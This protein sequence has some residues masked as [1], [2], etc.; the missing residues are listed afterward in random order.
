MPYD[1]AVFGD[2]G[3]RDRAGGVPSNRYGSFGVAKT[4]FGVLTTSARY[5]F[6]STLKGDSIGDVGF[7][8]ASDYTRLE[9]R[10]QTIEYG[11]GYTTQSGRYFGAFYA[12][13]IAGKNYNRN[14]LWGLTISQPLQF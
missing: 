8:G 11:L 13:A 3:Y 2:V 14:R 5:S 7:V 10:H 4:F 6:L 12:R 1:T 9:Q